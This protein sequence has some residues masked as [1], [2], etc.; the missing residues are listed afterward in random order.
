MIYILKHFDNLE[1]NMQFSLPR[2]LVHAMRDVKAC[3]PL[4]STSHE[5]GTQRAVCSVLL[6]FSNCWLYPY[7]SGLLHWYWGNH[8]IAPAP[9]IQ[10]WRI[11]VNGWHKSTENCFYDYKTTT[12]HVHNPWDILHITV[13]WNHNTLILLQSTYDEKKHT[14][15][16]TRYGVMLV[17]AKINCVALLFVKSC[18]VM[19]S[20]HHIFYIRRARH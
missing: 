2:A 19:K 17:S 9:V 10:P 18:H 4:S 12:N 13:N 1:E 6:S 11:W 8:V 3:Y 16:I 15:V 20:L 5:L 7:P 14:S